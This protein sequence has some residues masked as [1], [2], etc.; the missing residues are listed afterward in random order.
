MVRRGPTSVLKRKSGS[1]VRTRIA[2]TG[3]ALR[4]ACWMVRTAGASAFRRTR[5]LRQCATA[6]F[7]FRFGWSAV[8]PSRPDDPLAAWA[9]AIKDGL[10]LPRGHRR[11]RRAAFLRGILEGGTRAAT[12]RAAGRVSLP[13]RD[14]GLAISGR[15][16]VLS[17][18]PALCYGRASVPQGYVQIPGGRAF[19]RQPR[20]DT[21]DGPDEA[22]QFARD[23]GDH[24]QLQLTRQHH[25][26][27]APAQPGLRLPGD[28][29]H[30]LR[31]SLDRHQLRARDPGRAG[32]D[33]ARPCAPPRYFLPR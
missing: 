25:L 18:A 29:A 7:V 27:I 12:L 24:D 11:R 28:R 21:C 16:R 20:R 30:R 15:G 9:V 10:A 2:L 33:A 31:Y 4:R 6:A 32:R 19:R 1:K 8:F 13:I 17:Y 5:D 3:P 23:R 22:R 14:R 26:P